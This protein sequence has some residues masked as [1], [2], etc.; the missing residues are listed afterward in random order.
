[1]YNGSIGL[2]IYSIASPTIG[3]GVSC[4]LF[5]RLNLFWSVSVYFATA[6]VALLELLEYQKDV[7]RFRFDINLYS[8]LFPIVYSRNKS[9]RNLDFGFKNRGNHNDYGQCIFVCGSIDHVYNQL[10]FSNLK[11]CGNTYNILEEHFKCTQSLLFLG[12][13]ELEWA[14]SWLNYT[15]P[16]STGHKNNKMR[17]KSATK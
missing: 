8:S 5:N 4:S 9:T 7:R 15:L 11:Y 3:V 2:K 16:F 14:N 10:V 17:W 1:M 12:V 13:P 6:S